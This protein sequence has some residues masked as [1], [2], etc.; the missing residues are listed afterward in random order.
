MNWMK[1][2][3]MMA[4]AAVLAVSLAACSSVPANTVHSMEDLAGKK[5]GV[6]LGTV[7]DSTASDYES[8]GA[9]VERYSKASDAVQALKQGKID[10]VIIDQQPANVFV[11]KNSDLM[12][13]EEKFEPEEYAIAV[14]KDSELTAKINAALAQMTEDGTMQQIVD[15]YI[16]DKKGTCPYVSPEGT[17]RSGGTLVM[18]TNAEFEPYEYMQDGKIVGIDAEMAQ[19][20]CD[21]LGMELKIENMEFD[22]IIAAIQSGKADFGAA[23]MSVTPDRLENVDFTDSYATSAQVIIVRAK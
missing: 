15:N 6:Q 11:E 17:D 3:S 10:C 7:G 13:L 20:V 22:S 5:I 23:G 1:R 21:I 16:G 14:A 18:A 4:A 9:T 19:A 12:I 2:V 8:E